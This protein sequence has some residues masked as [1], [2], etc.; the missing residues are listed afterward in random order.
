M[1]GLLEIMVRGGSVNIGGEMF[2][3]GFRSYDRKFKQILKEGYNS[4]QIY[5]CD[6]SRL[7]FFI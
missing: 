7:N 5:N 4:E 6:K 2:V 1:A 3:G